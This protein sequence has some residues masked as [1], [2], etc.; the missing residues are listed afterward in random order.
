[1]GEAAL[2]EK[3]WK[4]RD[5]V[6]AEVEGSL[7]LLDLE[8]LAYHSLNATATAV[9]ELLE[10]PAAEPKLVEALCARYDVAPEHCAASVAKLLQTFSA[11]NLVTTMETPA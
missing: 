11:S 1:M 2:S 10:Q 8:T 5:C 4:R 7:V 9:W 3:V 6:S